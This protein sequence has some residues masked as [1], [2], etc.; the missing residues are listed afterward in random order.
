MGCDIHA[1]VELRLADGQWHHWNA[2]HIDRD[3]RLFA[4]L[5]GERNSDHVQPVAEK[6][7]LPEGLSLATR[8]S[9]EYWGPDGHGHS[10]IDRKEIRALEDWWNAHVEKKMRASFQHH[11]VF[12]NAIMG[13]YLDGNGYGHELP[14]GVEDVRMVFWFDN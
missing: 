4:H 6:R 12:E 10:W 14:E 7:G 8:R 1:H 5:A 11:L 9:A 3:Y 2:P 13:G